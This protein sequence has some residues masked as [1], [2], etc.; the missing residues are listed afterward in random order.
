MNITT[1]TSPRLY[2]SRSPVF[3]A[4]SLACGLALPAALACSQ[5]SSGGKSPSG[6]KCFSPE[7]AAPELAELSAIDYPTSRVWV[8]AAVPQA[9]AV[10]RIAAEIPTTLASEKDRDIGALG[11]ATYVVTR[12]APA[13]VETDRGISVQV[14]ISAD[15]SVCKQIGASCIKYAGCSPEFEVDF[16]VST[17]VGK[18]YELDAPTGTI[19]TKKKC[20]IGVDVTPQIESIAR[21]EVQN[22][23][24]QI[25]KQWPKLQP[26]AREAWNELRHPVFIDE[27]TCV[28]LSPRKVVYRRP[29][30]NGGGDSQIIAGLGITGELRPLTSCREELTLPPLPAPKAVEKIPANSRLWV[31]EVISLDEVRAALEQSSSKAQREGES[32][33]VLDVRLDAST[34]ALRVESKGAVCGTF[35][36]TGKLTHKKGQASLSLSDLAVSGSTETPEQMKQLLAHLESVARVPLSSADWFAETRLAPLLAIAR[37]AIPS[38][39]EFQ[40]AG[41][42]AGNARVVAASDGLYVLHPLTADLVVTKF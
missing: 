23:Q 12:K 13:L 20:V 41:L 29:T 26:H 7:E 6:G 16:S 35:W 36:V 1:V 18:N 39:V 33:K 10:Q 25:A 3:A 30:L 22:A 14:P 32:L 15:I 37:S 31:P 40:V 28:H 27:D 24:A 11:Q 17:Q 4:F 21:K 34:V 8:R 42:K 19:R 2:R 5:S 9:A 38:E